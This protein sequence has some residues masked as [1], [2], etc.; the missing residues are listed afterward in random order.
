MLSADKVPLKCRPLPDRD[1][2]LNCLATGKAQSYE[3][4]VYS[5]IALCRSLGIPSRLVL[6][7]QPLSAKVDPNELQGKLNSKEK[8]GEKSSEAKK[9]ES[10]KTTSLPKQRSSKEKKKGQPM[11]KSEKQTKKKPVKDLVEKTAEIKS[12]NRESSRKKT[13]ISN[14]SQETV[15]TVSKK[16]RKATVQQPLDEG[17]QIPGNCQV[18]RTRRKSAEKPVRYEESPLEDSENDRKTSRVQ[19]SRLRPAR[20]PTSKTNEKREKNPKSCDEYEE[21]S[22]EETDSEKPIPSSSKLLVAEKPTKIIST[23]ESDE[24]IKRNTTTDVWLEVYVEQEE[25]WISVDVRKGRIHCERELEKN[26]ESILYVVAFNPDLTW[27][28]V[29][30]RYASSFL[31][32]TRKQ[33]LHPR[34]TELLSLNL[35]RPSARSK[36]EDECLEKS[37]TERPIPGSISELKGHP[38]YVLQRHLLKVTPTKFLT[39]KFINVIKKYI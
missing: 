39:I 26:S 11:T 4:L 23:D 2:V 19:I 17:K 7:L 21:S 9:R 32:I 20:K 30:A 6:S 1:T 34:W 16:S 13:S 28:D 38:L 31:S 12:V 29:T 3:E 14:A 18:Q 35:E 8:S 10:K 15:P 24:P 5:S 37:L 36:N 33:R 25:Q 22:S 27:K